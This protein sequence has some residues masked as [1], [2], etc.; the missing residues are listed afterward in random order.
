MIIECNDSLKKFPKYEKEDLFSYN[1]YVFPASLA[2]LKPPSLKVKDMLTII[3]SM[4]DANIELNKRIV[5]VGISVY[6]RDKDI[7][8]KSFLA[9]AKEIGTIPC[10]RILSKE[11]ELEKISAIEESLTE[12]FKE[13]FRGRAP[14]IVHAMAVISHIYKIPETIIVES[15]D[16]NKIR[17][18]KDC[19]ENNRLAPAEASLLLVSTK[20]IKSPAIFESKA[21]INAVS[22]YQKALRKE[23]EKYKLAGDWICEHPDTNEKLLKKIV[24]KGEELTIN[25]DTLVESIKSQLG[26]LSSLT[27]VQKIEKAYKKCGFKF[28]DC[29]FELKFSETIYDRYRCEILRAGDTR[30]V[31]LG[32]F[33]NCC[34]KLNDAG[35]SAMMHGLLN[36]KAGFWCITDER[37]GRVVAQAEIWEKENDS[38]TLVFDNIEFAND[39]DISLYKDAIAEWL[40]ESPYKNIYMG[41]G[42][43]EMCYNESFRQAD[44]LTPPVT[45]YEIYVIS[46]EDGSEAPVF[47]SEQEAKEALESGSVTY[48]DYIYCDSERNTVVLKENGVLEPYFTQEREQ[49]DLEEEVGDYDEL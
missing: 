45:P 8:N 27:E 47:N 10:Y 4:M 22:C 15:F 41:A 29:K 42:Y 11:N 34:Q 17:G 46:H 36:P 6:E 33:T 20:D 16:R 37:N 40:K 18:L 25:K 3:C 35:E 14:A 13:K 43:N 26:K 5:K 1:G 24:K 44:P 23:S 7:F 2:K 49:E 21:A 48:Y 32:E 30:M 31:Y 12:Q 39:A 28:K 19:L 38:D 9:N